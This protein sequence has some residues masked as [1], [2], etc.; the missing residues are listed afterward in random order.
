[1]K[2]K[3]LNWL[4]KGNENI[5]AE[6]MTKSFYEEIPKNLNEPT[7]DFLSSNKDV[8]ERFLTIQAYYITRRSIG[9]VKKQDFYTGIL[10]YIKSLISLTQRGK[11]IKPQV[12][13][14]DKEKNPIEGVESFVKDFF[15]NE[16]K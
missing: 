13:I 16:K 12:V 1:M 8:L 4:Y 7:L 2:R 11:I 10:F 9:D 15:K 6:I 3:F 5:F 14:E